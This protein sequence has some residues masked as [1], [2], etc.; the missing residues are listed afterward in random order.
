[1]LALWD[2]RN[3]LKDSHASSQKRIGALEAVL[4][5]LE[6]DAVNLR[7]ALQSTAHMAPEDQRIPV[8]TGQVVKDLLVMRNKARAA[9]AVEGKT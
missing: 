8:I 3:V 2:D 7:C 6:A 5:S 4:D 1:M 9:L